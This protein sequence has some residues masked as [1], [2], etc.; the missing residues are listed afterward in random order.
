MSTYDICMR[1]WVKRS[2]MWC[3]LTWTKLCRGAGDTFLKCCIGQPEHNGLD[4]CL[5]LLHQELLLKIF[6]TTTAWSWSCVS[7]L[8]PNIAL[9]LIGA[10]GFV[11]PSSVIITFSAA[12]KPRHFSKFSVRSCSHLIKWRYESVADLS[13]PEPLSSNRWSHKCHSF[14]FLY[15]MK[16]S[17]MIRDR[18]DEILGHQFFWGW[19]STRP[20]WGWPRPDICPALPALHRK[21]TKNIDL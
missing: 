19:W 20:R 6:N 5:L 16:W 8:L 14:D 17:P 4:E 13:D 21:Y 1:M 7:L 3:T 12:T 9:F 11:T 10:F 18:F 2:I 15:T